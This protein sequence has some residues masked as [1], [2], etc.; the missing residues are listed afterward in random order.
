MGG[1]RFEVWALRGL[2]ALG[3]DVKFHPR[4]LVMTL[5]LRAR[6]LH[7]Q[8]AGKLALLLALAAEGFATLAPD[9][10]RLLPIPRLDA[11]AR[12]QF[13]FSP[14]LFSSRVSHGK[15]VFK[16]Y[17]Y[18]LLRGTWPQ[19]LSVPPHNPSIR[20]D[21]LHF[22]IFNRDLF[23]PDVKCRSSRQARSSGL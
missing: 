19:I 6:M 20:R 10:R 7:T 3:A 22:L 11:Q 1:G 9:L 17:D 16:L 12:W 8:A 2:L 14:L 15:I 4:R 23:L 21:I 18:F 13:A 5:L